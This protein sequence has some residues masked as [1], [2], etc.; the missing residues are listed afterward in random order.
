MG[1]AINILG[2]LID[3]PEISDAERAAAKVRA[4]VQRSKRLWVET[5]EKAA[6]ALAATDYLAMSDRRPMTGAE[7]S[8]REALRKIIRSEP[9]GAAPPALP[10][11]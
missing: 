1:K 11:L 10:T 8:Y 5:K 2:E 3:T 6:R 9:D 4:D 7:K